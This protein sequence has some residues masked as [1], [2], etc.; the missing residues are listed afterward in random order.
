VDLDQAVGVD[1]RQRHL[2]QV[3]QETTTGAGTAFG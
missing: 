2:L 1:I 3:L